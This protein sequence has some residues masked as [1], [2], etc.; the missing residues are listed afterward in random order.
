MPQKIKNLFYHGDSSDLQELMYDAAGWAQ[1]W[2]DILWFLKTV[3]PH[4]PMFTGWDMAALAGYVEHLQRQGTRFTTDYRQVYRE[5]TGQECQACAPPD[6]AR[7]PKLPLRKI[8]DKWLE[9]LLF[10]AT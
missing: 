3:A 7:A 8:A 6:D 10:P 4:D 2:D 5:L 9:G 1:N